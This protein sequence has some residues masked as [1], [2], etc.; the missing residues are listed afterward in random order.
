MF[1]STGPVLWMVTKLKWPVVLL[2]AVPDVTETLTDGTMP[3]TPHPFRRVFTYAAGL[4]Q[5]DQAMA[6]HRA[7]RDADSSIAALAQS[8]RP[9]WTMPKTTIRST[10]LMR[11][12]STATVPWHAGSMDVRRMTLIS[13]WL[14]PSA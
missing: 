3:E 5:Y 6:V 13:V 2:Q 14:L 1:E 10:L 7:V 8:S 4:V 12:N 9:P 11:A